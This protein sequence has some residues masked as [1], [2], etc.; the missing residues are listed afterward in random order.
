MAEFRSAIPCFSVADVG[1]TISWYEEQLGFIGEPFP[2]TEPYVFAI[3]YR[4][5]VEIMLQRME[6]YQKADL[7]SQRPGGSWDAYLR[8]EGVEDLYESLR[9]EATIV[10]PLRQLPYG[11]WE[12]EVKDPNGYIL[13]FSEFEQ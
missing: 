2:E 3:I 1:A 12:F 5:Q 13:V 10:K 11:A 4:D 6:G 7:Y 9:E 8:I